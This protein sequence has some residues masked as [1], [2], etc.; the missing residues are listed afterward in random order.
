[1]SKTNKILA[2]ISVFL[3]VVIIALLIIFL[4]SRKTKTYTV[5]FNTNGGTIVAEQKVTKNQKATKPLNPTK[6]GYT[7]VEWKL[8][9]QTYNFNTPVTKDLI[10][11]AE[12]K[13]KTESEDGDLITVRFDTDGGS[14]ISRQIIEKGKK[15]TKPKDPIKKDY[16]FVEWQLDD[17]TFDFDTELEE[18]TTLKAKWE[19]EGEKVTVTFNSDGGS[20]VASQSIEKGKKVTKPKDPTKNGYTFNGWTLNGISYNFNNTVD[21]DITLKATWKT[22]TNTTPSSN[23]NTNTTP[24]NNTTPKQ[25]YTV[26]F[27]LDGGTGYAPTQTVEEGMKAS[28]P[29]V[30]SKNGYTFAGWLLGSNKYNFNNPVNSNLSLRASWVEKTYVLRVTKVDQYSPDCNLALYD[31]FN[32]PVSYKKIKYTDG[33]GEINGTSANIYAFDDVSK[34]Y[35]ILTDDRQVTAEVKK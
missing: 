1:M 18:N 33:S 5:I 11:I 14:T 26:S 9:N 35:V 7:F 29:S 12:W 24:S 17:E 21:K 16:K 22:S 13:K 32:N 8:D 20:N 4:T 27:N 30:P 19:K 34:V 6:N 3:I 31:N 10:L 23:T 25:K 2:G 15:A 28:E